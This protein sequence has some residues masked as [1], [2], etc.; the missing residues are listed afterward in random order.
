MLKYILLFI[1]IIFI[2]LYIIYINNR[3]NNIDNYANN[4]WVD[5][6]PR[7]KKYDCYSNNDNTKSPPLFTTLNY[8]QNNP[9]FLGKEWKKVSQLPSNYTNEINNTEF[10]NYITSKG[11]P[12]K[13]TLDT[14][15]KESIFKEDQLNYNSYIKDSDN[16][17]YIVIKESGLKCFIKKL[18]CYITHLSCNNTRLSSDFKDNKD[19]LNELIKEKKDLTDTNDTLRSQLSTK[20]TELDTKNTELDTTNT[21]LS[22]CNTDKENLQDKI[23][24]L[25]GKNSSLT[26][27]NNDLKQQLKTKQEELETEKGK[28]SDSSNFMDDI[29]LGGIGGITPPSD[30]SPP[31]TSPS[32]PATSGGNGETLPGGG[33]NFGDPNNYEDPIDGSVT[34]QPTVCTINCSEYKEKIYNA[35]KN[36]YKATNDDYV[37]KQYYDIADTSYII[38]KTQTNVSNSSTKGSSNDEA[39]CKFNYK[40]KPGT[41]RIDNSFEPEKTIDGIRDYK[42]RKTP[43]ECKW[44]I[45]GYSIIKNGNEKTYTGDE[46]K[47]SIG[48]GLT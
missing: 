13:I 45:D 46:I 34:G 27:Q 9:S 18:L 38:D 29:D 39:Y 8:C 17:Y 30:T 48:S 40:S 1:I 31:A 47:T 7:G 14:S 2:I 21:E 35:Y 15:K 43:N 41:H 33:L 25:N 10:T 22:E 23:N 16:N 5:I 3:N 12:A 4:N 24:I 26:E 20:S 42:F 11:S 32:P 36:E 28:T 37:W 19:K 44:N 6:C